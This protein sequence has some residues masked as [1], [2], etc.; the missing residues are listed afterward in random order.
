M[1]IRNCLEL[2]NQLSQLEK[3]I[4][5]LRSMSCQ[6]SPHLEFDTV[7]EKVLAEYIS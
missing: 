3:D 4:E 7:L 6:I 2:L 5:T 1:I